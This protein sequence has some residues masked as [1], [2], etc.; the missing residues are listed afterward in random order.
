[1]YICSYVQNV[2]CAVNVRLSAF[3]LVTL[4]TPLCVHW[5]K[6]DLLKTITMSSDIS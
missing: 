3:F 2:T 1:M 5:S 6:L 4:I